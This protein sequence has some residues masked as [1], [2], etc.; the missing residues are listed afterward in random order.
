VWPIV[1]I[2]SGVAFVGLSTWVAV[3][4]VV[5]GERVITGWIVAA[6]PSTA[7]PVLQVANQLGHRLVLVPAAVVGLAL[8]IAREGRCIGAI[9]LLG[10]APAIEGGAAWAVGRSRPEG[11]GIGYPSGHV[12]GA[13]VVYG[14]LALVVSRYSAAVPVRWTAISGAVSIVALVAVARVAL[15]AHWPLDVV[16]GAV[17]GTAYLALGAHALQRHGRSVDRSPPL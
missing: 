9:V 5:P 14:F 17:G 12:F 16:G 13:A 3:A 8:Y 11:L 2:V 4:G 15:G 6:L 1:A 10:A 7:V